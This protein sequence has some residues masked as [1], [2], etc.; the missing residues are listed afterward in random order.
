MALPGPD[1]HRLIAPALAGAFLLDHLVGVGKQHRRHLKA[2]R[3]GGLEI[4]H[5]LIFRRLLDRQV[6]G[7]G[8]TKNAIDIG[9]R[10]PP[11]IDLV[12]SIGNESALSG[13][14]AKWIDRRQP[15]VCGQVDSQLA[16]GQG[17]RCHNQAALRQEGKLRNGARDFV[18]HRAG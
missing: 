11:L 15:M 16:P 7:I 13:M 2:E 12:N 8:A 14:K 3:P 1:L 17:M 5:Q 4:D 10:T 9:G 6:R 18:A